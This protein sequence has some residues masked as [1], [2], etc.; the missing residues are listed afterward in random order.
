MKPGAKSR[1]GSRR[2][3]FT[4]CRRKAAAVERMRERQKVN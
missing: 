1:G 4:F 2:G 3:Q